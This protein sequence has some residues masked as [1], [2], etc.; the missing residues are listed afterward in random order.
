MAETGTLESW[1]VRPAPQPEPR[2]RLFCFPYA[3]GSASVFRGW[4]SQMPRDVE[5]CAIQLPGRE[6]RFA[7]PPF[8]QL[9]AL[10]D[11]LAVAIR[12]YLGPA[13]LLF[14]HSMGALIAYE[15]ARRLR[16]EGRHGPVRLYVSAHRAP[17]LASRDPPIH[18]LPERE[19]VAELGR[20]NGTPA[21]VLGNAELRELMLPML[22]ADFTLSETYVHASGEL[23]ECSILAFAGEDDDVVESHAMLPWKEH[24]RGTFAL[25]TLPGDHF[26]LHSAREL[27]LAALHEDLLGLLA[28][29][30]GAPRP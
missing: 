3:G 28:S 14:G 9:A 12:P 4:S 22:R 8:A 30:H 18:H 27:V 1:V 24:T 25:R 11:A 23:L 6:D 20:L 21:D 26:F 2:L 16:S 19:F 10:I 7:E 29:A 17:H 15:L 13:F 5:V